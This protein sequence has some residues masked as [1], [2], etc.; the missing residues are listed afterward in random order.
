[1]VVS[2]I[3]LFFLTRHIGEIAEAK[4]EA[5]FRWKVRTIIAWLLGD[6][7]GEMLIFQSFGL[8]VFLLFLFGVGCGYVGYLVV[9]QKL[10]SLPDK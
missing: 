10:E 7:V 3:A 6:L 9:K 4:G 1:M 8:N 5:P 2:I